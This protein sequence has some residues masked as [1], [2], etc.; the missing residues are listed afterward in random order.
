M[1]PLVGI[2]D[3]PDEVLQHVLSFL[4]VREAVQTCVVARRWS[5][6]WRSMADLRL[7]WRTE[8][9]RFNHQEVENMN[10]FVEF[11]MLHRNHYMPLDS[12]EISI[13]EFDW[14][15][16]EPNVNLWIQQ[17]LLSQ[18][19][20]L[21]V[22]VS[23]MYLGIW[24]DDTPLISKHLTRLKL[25]FVTLQGKFLDFSSC[26]ALKDLWISD[27]S[28]SV[29]KISSQSLQHLTIIRS[30]FG[31]YIRTRISAPSLVG[32]QLTDNSKNPILESMP[33][34]VKGFVRLHD[35]DDS[36]E[37]CG[38]EKYGGSCDNNS[39]DNCADDSA[40]SRECVL[41]KGLS[42]AESLELVA[43]PETFI[44]KRDLMWCPI[45]SK[46]K[47]LLLNEWCV[48]LDF[49][50]L[51]CLLQHA[52]VLEKLTLQLGLAPDN[53]LEPYIPS[54]D[55]S[56]SKNLKVIE[57]KCEK[58]DERV[59]QVSRMLSI[60]NMYLEGI[61]IQL[62]SKCSECEF[63]MVTLLFYVPV[64]HRMN[65]YGCACLCVFVSGLVA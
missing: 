17:A 59:H 20:I 30:W 41:L 48:A 62:S 18:V 9:Y 4:P 26:P 55:P 24:L 12:C 63:P 13:S 64:V 11:L 21:R 45:F 39:C 47:T 42:Q 10:R 49:R 16:S 5:Q 32:L 6:L 52:P 40:K 1:A 3:L 36:E 15:G 27:C 8:D 61:N 54:Q 51:I 29:K 22:E 2:E 38:K 7:I 58:F 57:I 43:E 35:R 31:V 25:R 50:P 56:A 19:R 37:R 23:T 14:I 53:W 65:Y 44:F 28:I 33:S 46:M 34:L 60:Y